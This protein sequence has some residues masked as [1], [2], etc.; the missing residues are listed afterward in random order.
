MAT[1]KKSDVAATII[2]QQI[3]SPIRREK[4][5]LINLKSLGLG[6]MNRVREVPDNAC[7]RGL[8]TKISHMVKIVD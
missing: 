7:T 4:S 6:K 8:I 5:Q 2:V 1:K 3:G